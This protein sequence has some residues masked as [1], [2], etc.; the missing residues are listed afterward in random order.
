MADVIRVQRINQDD[1]PTLGFVYVNG[2]F[3]C[4]SL[5]DRYRKEKVAGDTRIPAGEYKLTWRTAGRWAARFIREG[6]PG[7]L[8]LQDVPGFSTVLL[9]IGNTKK[10]T[11]GCILAGLG[12]DVKTR[13]ITRSAD[14]CRQLY[15]RV[16]APGSEWSVLIQ[17]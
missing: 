7:S 12:A 3:Q 5:E 4:F 13:T 10:D 8:W 15:S 14:A 16:A 11:E 9:H 2:V 1:S 6:F 17:D